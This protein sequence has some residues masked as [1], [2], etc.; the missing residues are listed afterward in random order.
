MMC[1]IRVAVMAVFL[2]LNQFQIDKTTKSI[3]VKVHTNE[4]S[5]T[6]PSGVPGAF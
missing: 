2:P 6:E 1:V 4:S 3:W 5:I